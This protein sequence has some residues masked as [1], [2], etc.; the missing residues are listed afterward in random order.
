MEVGT[1]TND[2]NIKEKVQTNSLKIQKSG[3]LIDSKQKSD[4]HFENKLLSKVIEEQVALQFHLQ[5]KLSNDDNYE[6]FLPANIKT[7][8]EIAEDELFLKAGNTIE[9][10]NM[11]P[12][13]IAFKSPN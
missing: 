9:A 6:D 12:S 5:S 1:Q 3:V 7:F 10:K 11:D 13:P 8:K 4:H 2:P